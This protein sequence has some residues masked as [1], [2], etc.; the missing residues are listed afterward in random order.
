MVGIRRVDVVAAVAATG[1][2]SL[3]EEIREPLIPEDKTR[4]DEED[5]YGPKDL[6]HKSCSTEHE[7]MVYLSTFV[8]VCGS[9]AFGTCAG[10]SLPTQLA[11]TDNL[12]LSLAE[13]PITALG[14]TLI[15]KAGRKPLFIGKS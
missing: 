15:D 9:Y 2:N 4:A 7:W 13:V 8:A 11:I 6:S 1:D 10:Y 14:A 5:G 3:Q 12:D